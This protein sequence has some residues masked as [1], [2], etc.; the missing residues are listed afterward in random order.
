MSD[1]ALASL[2]E[3]LRTEPLQEAI[4]D[5]L[6]ELVE[7]GAQPADVGE[8]A[9]VVASSLMLDVEGIA[10]TAVRLLTAGTSLANISPELQGMARNKDATSRNRHH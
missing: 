10:K 8:M 1:H 5:K 7:A 9:L 6:R 3:D 2:H 4:R